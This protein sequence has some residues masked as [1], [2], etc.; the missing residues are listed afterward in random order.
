MALSIRKMRLVSTG[1]GSA[2]TEILI[3]D[4]SDA[5]L[6]VESLRIRVRIPLR[7]IDVRK[8]RNLAMQRAGRICADIERCLADARQTQSPK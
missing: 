7:E 6:A 3:T 5:E 8:A 1:T 4:H 2:M